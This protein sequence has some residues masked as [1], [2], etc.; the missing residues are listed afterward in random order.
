MG[1][2]HPFLAQ[3]GRPALQ[4]S[5]DPWA[6][7]VDLELSAGPSGGASSPALDVKQCF[8]ESWA[9]RMLKSL[10][11]LIFE[12]GSEERCVWFEEIVIFQKILRSD[13]CAENVAEGNG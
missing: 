2:G 11:R 3:Q 12:K 4:D 6:C 7:A 5:G 9:M 10:M 1:V 8:P 13:F